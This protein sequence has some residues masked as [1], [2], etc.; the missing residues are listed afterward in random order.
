[1]HWWRKLQQKL[2]EITGRDRSARWSL[3]RNDIGFWRQVWRWN[4][5]ARLIQ[6]SLE[7]GHLV[8][9]CLLFFQIIHFRLQLFRYQLQI[10]GAFLQFHLKNWISS[11][12]FDWIAER[13]YS[14]FKLKS[15]S[16]HIEYNKNNVKITQ[17]LIVH[18]E[19]RLKT[20][21]SARFTHLS[22]FHFRH[23][24]AM[25]LLLFSL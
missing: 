19:I 18:F 24:H 15:N 8:S 14:T 17:I 22:S 11:I 9:F 1:M 5:G 12:S 10:F 7:H 6:S 4:V 13:L 25:K 3:R 16:H 20:S 21:S 23:V 2:H